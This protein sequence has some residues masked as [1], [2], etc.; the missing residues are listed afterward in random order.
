M[1]IKTKLILSLSIL[2]L[3]IIGIGAM[4]LNS[5][6]RLGQQDKI[7]QSISTA[8][9]R[10]YQARLAQADYIITQQPEF[11]DKVGKYLSQANTELDNVLSMMEVEASRDQ[12]AQIKDA[13]GNYQSL[14]DRLVRTDSA[15]R[16]A[17]LTEQILGAANEASRTSDS[18]LA[19]ETLIA[20]QVRDSVSSVIV[21]IV[22][23]AM[24]VSTIIAFRLVQNI[25]QPLKLSNRIAKAIADGDLTYSVQVEGSDEFASLNLALLSS[26]ETLKSTVSNIVDVQHRLHDISV[27]VE[28]SVKDANASVA[29]QQSETAQLATA[30]EEL[31]ASTQEIARNA[32]GAAESSAK[33]EKEALSGDA[34]VK[35][36]RDA[37]QKLSQALQTASEVV[38]RL[39]NNS[40]AIAKIV[41]VI[42][43]IAE[44]TNLL[45][46]NAAIEAARAGEQGRGFAVVADEVRKLAQRTQ[47]STTEINQ[48]VEVIQQG[49]TD[50]VNVIEAANTESSGVEALTNDASKA[51]TSIIELINNLADL[52][53]QVS[54]GAA[55][56]ASVSEVVSQ[57][58]VTIKQ[59]SDSN[60]QALHNI[61]QQT[62][63]QSKEADSLK[64]MVA[65]FKV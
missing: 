54:V 9:L 26:I 21:W 27:D 6:S 4:S 35:Q 3:I 24:I 23:I 33:T 50:V 37:M 1:N 10:L 58:V 25:I 28:R 2:T 44:Q 45:A 56:Q 57:N 13:I 51:Y 16:S 46:L 12:V 30:L 20:Q 32:D 43:E 19:E 22:V 38:A 31:A 64:Q 34:V 47:T 42:Q 14:F 40:K 65:F 29:G 18:L 39:D 60:T 48:L 52:N 53:T 61:T 41:Q 11:V 55:E 63:K 5:L 17:A 62:V 36:S 7:F 8:D 15:N 59:L 49:A